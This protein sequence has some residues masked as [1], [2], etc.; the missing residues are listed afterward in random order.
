MYK[1]PH[2]V[3]FHHQQRAKHGEHAI[4]P[5][6]PYRAVRA[7]LVRRFTPSTPV[8][9]LPTPADPPLKDIARKYKIPCTNSYLNRRK[10][11][12]IRMYY[13]CRPDMVSPFAYTQGYRASLAASL[14]SLSFFLSLSFSSLSLISLPPPPAW[15]FRA[16]KSIVLRTVTTRPKSRRV[17]RTYTLSTT[18]NTVPHQASNLKSKPNKKETSLSYCS[19]TVVSTMKTRKHMSQEPTHREHNSA[20]GFHQPMGILLYCC[21]PGTLGRA[22]FLTGRGVGNKVSFSRTTHACV[23]RG[24]QTTA[25]KIRMEVGNEYPT[26]ARSPK[27]YLQYCTI[28]SM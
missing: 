10:S 19:T 15:P 3:S 6:P 28:I 11:I 24:A 18:I 1:L 23:K 14:V 5:S 4:A 26:S 21:A 9:P 2:H 13:Y 12:Y 25:P 22:A 8:I 17:L 27:I 7:T 16:L 20:T